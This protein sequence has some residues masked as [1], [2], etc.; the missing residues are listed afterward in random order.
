MLVDWEIMEL[1]ETGTLII[2]PFDESL[3][4]P[5]S[6]DFR[7]GNKFTKT[8]PTRS[9]GI[10]N[11]SDKTS[12]ENITVEQ[13]FYLLKPKE[14]ILATTLETVNLKKGIVAKVMGKSTWARQGLEQSSPGGYIDVGFR[15]PIT[16]E[17]YNY[18]NNILRIESGVKAGQL[19]FYPAKN[20]KK[21][22]LETGQ[23]N[24]QKFGA[25]P[26]TVR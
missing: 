12:F 3:I 22:Y 11:P 8:V 9:D 24:D 10:I 18:S 25:G 20:P 1:I 4:N 2:D 13:E 5:A 19:V 17:L 16:L 6:L 14:F 21:S 15:G 7:L 23:Y 26:G